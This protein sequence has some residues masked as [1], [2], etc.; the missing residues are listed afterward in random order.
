MTVRPSHREARGLRRLHRRADTRS[1][2]HRTR[3][4][5]AVGRGWTGL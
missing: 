5:A 3:P 2:R 4:R 1:P